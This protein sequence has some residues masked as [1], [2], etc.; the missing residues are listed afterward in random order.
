MIAIAT[1][2]TT[3]REIGN[4]DCGYNDGGWGGG[5]TKEI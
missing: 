5:N 2:K 3:Y 4:Y 1:P